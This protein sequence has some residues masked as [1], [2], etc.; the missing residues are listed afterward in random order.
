[1]GFVVSVT[2]GGGSHGFRVCVSMD[3]GGSF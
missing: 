3:F 1:V 2:G